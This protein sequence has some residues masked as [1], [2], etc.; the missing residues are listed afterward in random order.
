MT[1]S[2]RLVRH[3]CRSETEWVE[4]RRRRLRTSR[5]KACGQ[6]SPPTPMAAAHPPLVIEAVGHAAAGGQMRPCAL[7]IS[8][9]ASLVSPLSAWTGK[10]ISFVAMIPI[11][12][13]AVLK[14][15]MPVAS[16]ER[17]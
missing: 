5:N 1:L 11:A 15:P 7:T 2:K 13:I 16:A 17:P 12:S 6:H 14:A 10:A 3:G 4:L 9:T 8:R